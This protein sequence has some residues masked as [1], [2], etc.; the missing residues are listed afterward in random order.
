MT[1]KRGS[2]SPFPPTL[3]LQVYFQETGEFRSIYIDEDD[4]PA[5]NEYM[6]FREKGGRLQVKGAAWK[7]W[8]DLT[9][10]ITGTMCF[11][12]NLDICDFRR[13]N[14]TPALKPWESDRQKYT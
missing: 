5:I 14:L 1:S 3:V 6:D 8:K 2:I 9:Q 13:Q 11:F 4:R 10:Y 12:K 7:R